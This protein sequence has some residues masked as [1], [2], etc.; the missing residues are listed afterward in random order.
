MNDEIAA[1][2]S[3]DHDRLDALLRRCVLPSGGIDADAYHAFRQGLL[4]H[5]GI[6]ERI[7]IPALRNQSEEPLRETIERIRLD[8]SAIAA[9][10]VPVPSAG[11]IAALTAILTGHNDLEERDGGFYERADAYDAEAAT[12]MMDRIRSAPEVRALP[13]NPDPAVLAATRRALERAGYDAAQ[14]F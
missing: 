4:R 1:Y 13:N 9:L 2:L 3:E 12:G 7:L 11:I 8:H 5:I 14:Y 10:L 6:E